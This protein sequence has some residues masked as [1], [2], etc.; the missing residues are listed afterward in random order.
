[1]GGVFLDADER[2]FL[3]SLA[4]GEPAWDRLAL[5]HLSALP[6]IQWKLQNLAKLKATNQGKFEA[7]AGEL[8]TKIA[9]IATESESQPPFAP[10]G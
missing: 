6:A 7:Q 2:A 4:S 10:K 3:I 1:L 9:A 8:A 5:P